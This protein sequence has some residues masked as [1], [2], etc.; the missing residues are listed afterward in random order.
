MSSIE[1]DQQPSDF[2]QQAS[3][4]A[5]R[6]KGRV[7]WFNNKAG[8]GFL[9][10]GEGDDVEDVFVHH[11]ALNTKEEQYKYAVEGEYVEFV[12]TAA[13]SD[14]HKWQASAVT[15]LG[16]GPLLCETR[17]ARRARLDDGDEDDHMAPSNRRGPPRSRGPPHHAGGRPRF[18]NAGPRWVDEEDNNYEWSL[19]RRRRVQNSSNRAPVSRHQRRDEEEETELEY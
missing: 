17:N 2:D 18:N 13:D 4:S 12:M 16:G 19:V 15:G 6:T 8:Y 14:N 7:K 11:S 10:V 5:E 9:T 3:V 1:S